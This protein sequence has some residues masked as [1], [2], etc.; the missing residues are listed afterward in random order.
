MLNK[1]FNKKYDS[2]FL[3]SLGLS[4][5][6]FLGGYFSIPFIQLH[7][8]TYLP[9]DLGDSRLNNYFLENIYLF[10]TQASP[11]LIHLSFFYPFPYV[12]GFSDNLFGA[13]PV[14]FV[15]RLFTGNSETAFAFWYGFSYV[16]NY[17]SAYYAFRKLNLGILSAIIGALIFTFSFPVS[18][19]MGHVQLAYRFG[20]PLAIFTLIFFLKNKSWNFFFLSF[21]WLVWQFYCSIYIGFFLAIF[22]I[23][24]FLIYF[25]SELITYKDRKLEMHDEFIEGWKVIKWPRKIIWTLFFLALLCSLAALFYPYLRVSQLYGAKRSI[26][27]IATM[28]PRPSSYFLIDGSW[29][30]S[31]LSKDIVNIPMRHEHQI[32]FGGLPLLL[33]F[34]GLIFR[35]ASGNLF[36]FWL[37]FLSFI[38]V[39]IFSISIN[40]HSIWLLFAQLPVFSAIRAVTRIILV[41]LFPIAY[42]AAVA[43]NSFPKNWAPSKF[44][45]AS[46]LIFEFSTASV[47][48]TPIFTWRDHVN[49]ASQKVPS[50]LPE[51]P[52]LFF[53]QP[54]GA[55]IRDQEIDSMWVALNKGYPTLNGYSGNSPP[56]YQEKYGEDCGEVSRRVLAYL[57]FIK[58][59]NPEVEYGRL[60]KRI[61]PI[62]FKDCDLDIIITYKK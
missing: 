25:F 37:I 60:L 13:F 48:A 12:M 3:L 7:H 47:L 1:I 50:K 16:V 36:A 35:R 28:L 53:A 15:S 27:E 34:A 45:I 11:S 26:E 14:Y 8:L 18:A 17:F 4:T 49:L 59:P 44:C 29:L 46:L 51:N 40:S 33:A 5:F 38:I 41:L 24:I 57:A 21:F 19:Q 6:F 56:G 32:F 62:G 9:G 39:V 10:L 20:V 54:P 31:F 23:S 42:L 55:Y 30:W 58:H 22:L 43:V 52:I 61:A 2:R